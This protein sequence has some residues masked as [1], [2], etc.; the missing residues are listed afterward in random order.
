MRI[1]ASQQH[2]TLPN[3]MGELP[4]IWH[5]RAA[6][7]NSPVM[8]EYAQM[9]APAMYCLQKC[10]TRTRV[11]PKHL[12]RVSVTRWD[13][14]TDIEASKTASDSSRSAGHSSFQPGRH[15]RATVVSGCKRRN[16]TP[17]AAIKE[18]GGVTPGYYSRSTKTHHALK[19]PKS[20]Y[21]KLGK[22]L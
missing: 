22:N 14:L 4:A 21:P 3:H 19:S 18:A 12:W 2:G 20:Y 9:L 7:A 13:D 16:L 5:P 15:I 10:P 6:T 8:R 17:R 11:A 1:L